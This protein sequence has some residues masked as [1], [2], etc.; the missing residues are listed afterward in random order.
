MKPT[1]LLMNPSPE[2]TAYV[3]THSPIPVLVEGQDDLE[4][5]LRAPFLILA[6]GGKDLHQADMESVLRK[7]S[8][9]KT[10][11]RCIWVPRVRGKAQIG[12]ALISVKE[13]LLDYNR[14]LWTWKTLYQK[15]LLTYGY[16]K[17]VKIQYPHKNPE[18]LVP[19]KL[20]H[21]LTVLALNHPFIL[22]PALDLYHSLK[23]FEALQGAVS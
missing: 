5:T 7:G 6:F 4:P 23:S 20:F 21:R 17:R 14:L 9:P 15:G 2:D 22:D 18:E 1:L 8:L 16:L 13:T 19:K 3:K 12:P 10:L 11:I